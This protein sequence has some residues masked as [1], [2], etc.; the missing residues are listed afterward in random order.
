[1]HNG[2]YDDGEWISWDEINVQL[3]EIELRES[4]NFEKKKPIIMTKN[5]SN[6][7]QTLNHINS[8]NIR[9]PHM[10]LHYKS[11]KLHQHIKDYIEGITPNKVPEDISSLFLDKIW[12]TMNQNL[13]KD[14]KELF[15]VYFI[16]QWTATALMAGRIFENVLKIHIEYDLKENTVTNIGNAIKILEKHNYDSVLIN[17]LNNFKEKR[18]NFMHGIKR[19]GSEDAKKFVIS[20]VS[21]TMSIHNIKP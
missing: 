7:P 20:V 2:I 12:D 8:T 3:D 14:I 17:E 15:E 6:K 16:R 11:A 5:K 18:N 10:A 9:K 1:M 21:V 4:I 19:A 13:Q